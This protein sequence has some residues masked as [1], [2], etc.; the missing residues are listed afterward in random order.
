MF[1]GDGS[2]RL[3]QRIKAKMPTEPKVGRGAWGE[4]GTLWILA[5][6]W[7]PCPFLELGTSSVRGAL[8]LPACFLESAGRV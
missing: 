1:P 7:A 3:A 2:R 4:A 5:L 8:D 6:A